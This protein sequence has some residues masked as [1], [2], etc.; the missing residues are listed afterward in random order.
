VAYWLGGF[1]LTPY[2]LDGPLPELPESN[3]SRAAQAHIYE[4]AR[5]ENL[6]IRQ[7]AQRVTDD[8]GT[9]VGTPTQIADHI[10]IWFREGAAD[11][12]NVIF[13]YLPGTLDDFADLV[14]PELRRRGIFR[15]EYE[16]STLREHLGLPRPAG[17]W[18]TA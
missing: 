2:P 10:E 18:A 4:A 9:I 14:I 15:T 3:Q 13:P 11:G 6:T 5:R 7:L 1:D 8:A 17:R 12:F 16:G